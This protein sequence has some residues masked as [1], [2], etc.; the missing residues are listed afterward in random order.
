M[1]AA[2]ARANFN[3]NK[4]GQL[5]INYVSNPVKS[6]IYAYRE[7]WEPWIEEVLPLER[8]PSHA[9]AIKNSSETVGHVPF[10]TAPV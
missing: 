8:N 1:T 10:T 3:R 7:Q 5:K 6:S 4:D 2:N 9:I